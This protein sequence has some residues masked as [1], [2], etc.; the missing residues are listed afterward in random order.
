[1]TC[2]REREEGSIGE[3]EKVCCVGLKL[4]PLLE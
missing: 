3:E 4:I 1:M 2:F